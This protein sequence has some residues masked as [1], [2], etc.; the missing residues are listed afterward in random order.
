[1]LKPATVPTLLLRY[2]PEFAIAI[3]AGS[4]PAVIAMK[5]VET[6]IPIPNPPP[7]TYKDSRNEVFPFQRRDRRR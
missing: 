1:M 2:K 6:K 5:E 7:N 3:S 4:T